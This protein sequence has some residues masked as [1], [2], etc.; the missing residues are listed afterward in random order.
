MTDGP[1][2]FQ[3]E[4]R[5]KRKHMM[6]SAELILVVK[7][8]ADDLDK[9]E[10][11]IVEEAVWADLIENLG[12]ERVM[13]LIDDAQDELEDDDRLENPVTVEVQA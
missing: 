13:E 8:L 3:R 4:G 7:E 1:I 6:M 12:E 9:S 2:S 5:R 11:S 10:S